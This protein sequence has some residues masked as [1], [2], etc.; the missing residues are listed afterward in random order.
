MIDPHVELGGWII[1]QAIKDICVGKNGALPE[2]KESAW[3]F[4]RNDPF[5]DEILEYIDYG[6]Q[7]DDKRNY[8]LTVIIPQRL[9][10][11]N[12]LAEKSPYMPSPFLHPATSS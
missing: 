5:V 11:K 6:R 12:Q 9:E 10:K 4:L 1:A 7:I 3:D 8:I 2:D